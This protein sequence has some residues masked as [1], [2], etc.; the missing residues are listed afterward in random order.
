MPVQE[1]LD[2]IQ[3]L[4]A[5][6]ALIVVFAHLWPEF[7]GYGAG[8]RFPMFIV[9]ASGVDLFFVISG[10]IMVYTAEPLFGQPGAPRQF[11]TRR[12]VRIVPLY[13]LATTIVLLQILHGSRDLST[14]NLT[15]ANVVSSYLFIPLGRPHGGETQPVLGVGWTLNYEMFFYCLFAVATMLPRRWAVLAVTVF[16]W[17]SINLPGQFGWPIPQVLNVWFGPTVYE[18]AFGMWIALAFREGLRIPA[19]ASGTLIAAG[20]ALIIL[21]DWDGFATIGR[22][23]GWGGGTAMIVAGCVLANVRPAR[24]VPWLALVFL[25][26]ASYALYLLHGFVLEK[27]FLA[28]PYVT[29]AR[30][31]WLYATAGMIASISVA[32]AAHLTLERPLTKALQRRIA[33]TPAFHNEAATA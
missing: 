16:F 33:A 14:S 30:H 2:S 20:S 17:S 22:V 26:D 24:S 13:W 23:S 25:G 11:F 28:A 7:A 18:F 8:D 31:V 15:W 21:T 12:L 27:L 3:V 9:G 5:C 19:W 1:R 4:R 10:F 29:P 6:A 32:V